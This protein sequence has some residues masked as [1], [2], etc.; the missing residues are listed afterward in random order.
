MFVLLRSPK[1]RDKID[2]SAWET[3]Y[4]RGL[5]VLFPAGFPVNSEEIPEK[6]ST[7]IL[8]YSGMMKFR[9]KYC[10]HLPV[11][12][13]VGTGENDNGSCRFLPVLEGGTMDLGIK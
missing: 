4:R 11:F 3:E 5:S 2:L 13:P 9:P 6:V 8:T 10:F 7:G 12:F 1:I